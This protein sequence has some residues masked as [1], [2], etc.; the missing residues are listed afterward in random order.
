MENP[1]KDN[2]EKKSKGFWGWVQEHVRPD[3]GID[4][5]QGNQDTNSEGNPNNKW[6]NF[7]HKVRI[8]FRLVWKF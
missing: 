4:P 1:S 3:I 5:T 7:I 8:G 2:T 6:E